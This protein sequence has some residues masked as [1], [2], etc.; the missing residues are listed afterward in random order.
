MADNCLIANVSVDPDTLDCS[1]A[2]QI[3]LLTGLRMLQ[4]ITLP[5]QQPL[6]YRTTL[7]ASFVLQILLYNV[8]I[9]QLILFQLILG[10][11]VGTD[12]CGSVDISHAD[13]IINQAVIQIVIPSGEHGPLK[14]TKR[15]Q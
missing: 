10:F 8:R 11:A 14:M 5:V 3:L 9:H 2:A 15:K 7:Q 13:A 1:N 4:E 6:L 12:N